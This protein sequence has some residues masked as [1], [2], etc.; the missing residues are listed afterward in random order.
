MELVL[1]L[2][3]L[4]ALDGHEGGGG[5]GQSNLSLLANCHNSTLSVVAC[6]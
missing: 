1:E 6:P 4:E 2:Q 3:S 5:G